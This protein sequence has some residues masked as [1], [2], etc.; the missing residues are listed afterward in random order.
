MI[1]EKQRAT[2]DFFL[3]QIRFLVTTNDIYSPTHQ[4]DIENDLNSLVIH[5]LFTQEEIN[6]MGKKM[7]DLLQFVRT[8][9]DKDEEKAE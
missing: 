3:D 6:E 8:I 4:S 7:S 1:N 9:K 2:L 5:N